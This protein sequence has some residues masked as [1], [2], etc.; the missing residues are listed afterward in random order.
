VRQFHLRFT[1]VTIVFPTLLF[2]LDGTLLQSFLASCA[3]L[4]AA[5]RS[6][7]RNHGTDLHYGAVA[8]LCGL[9]PGVRVLLLG[10]QRA[11]HAS[12]RCTERC[13]YTTSTNASGR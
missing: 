2:L 11:L 3:A 9:L 8:H 5:N 10:S 6:A 12:T 13:G 7:T 4:H 1:L